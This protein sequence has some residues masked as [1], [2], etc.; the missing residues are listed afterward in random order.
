MSSSRALAVG[1]IGLLVRDFAYA[2][3]GVPLPLLGHPDLVGF[4]DRAGLIEDVWNSSA[5]SAYG[6]RDRVFAAPS[7][8]PADPVEPVVGP[9]VLNSMSVGNACR[10][11]VSEIAL[12]PPG[13]DV[14]A[15][16]DGKIDCDETGVSG[17]R[18][19]DLLSAYDAVP[20][21]EGAAAPVPSSRT[22]CLEGLRVPTAAMLAARFPYLTPSGRVGPCVRDGRTQPPDQLVDGGYL[23]NTGLGTLVDTADVWLPAVQRWN[24][25]HAGAADGTSRVVIAP[26]VVY[27]DNATGNDQHA[28]Q[29]DITSEAMIPPLAKL[30]AGSGAVAADTTLQRAA[31]TVTPERV[32]GAT[33]QV[34]LHAL[35][36]VGHAVFRVFPGTRPQ[37]AAPLGWILSES[38]RRSMDDGV[39]EQLA[40]ELQRH[41]GRDPPLHRVPGRLRDARRPA[42]PGIPTLGRSDRF[43]LTGKWSL[44][45]VLRSLEGSGMTTFGGRSGPQTSIAAA[46]SAYAPSMMNALAGGDVVAHQH[47]ERRLGDQ[48]VVDGDPAQGAV[49]R[50]HGRL[51]QLVGVHLAQALVALRLLEPLVALGQLGGRALVLRVGVGVDEALLALLRVRQL[52]AV[53][54]RDRGEDPAGLDHGTHVAEE[55]RGQQAAD[56]GAVGVG[57]GH[58]DHP[59]VARRVEVERPPGARRR[60]PG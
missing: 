55:Q 15:R 46:S 20:T 2:A 43:S 51:G 30:R 36:G 59:A 44:R 25:A 32:C 17:L 6:W 24:A 3:T 31:D 27:L 18:S 13:D 41:P 52:E 37:V 11:W 45:H 19:V 5:Q 56:V 48:A 28:P 50:A 26:V 39:A 21:A 10:V 14:G 1:L 57:V 34:C 12:R 33:D 4:V 47:L 9:V 7:T 29:R 23:E 58:E 42:A 8:G 38:S 60:R 54:R 22:G 49:P 40:D 16:G 35:G 53:Q